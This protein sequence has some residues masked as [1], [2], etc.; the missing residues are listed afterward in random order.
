MLSFVPFQVHRRVLGEDRDALLALEVHRVHDALGDVLVGAEGAGLPEHG[1]DERRLAVVD[2]RDDRDV[3]EVGAVDVLRQANL[4]EVLKAFAEQNIFPL[5]IKGTPLS[6]IYYADSSLR[7]R[8]DTDLLIRKN[9]LN[10]VETILAKFG[11][12]RSNSVSGDFIRHQ[13]LYSKPG[14][15]GIGCDLDVHWKI[16]NPI[17][18]AD[19]LTFDELQSK[20]IGIPS[21]SEYARTVS[22]VD[23]LLLACLHR[24]AHHKSTERLIWLYDIHLMADRM[25]E[26]EF[27]EFWKRA[28]QKKLKS[29]CLDGLITAKS[30]FN[31]KF[32]EVQTDQ[33]GGQR[34][35]DSIEPSAQY[36]H[37]DLR[38]LD[39]LLMN[40]RHHSGWDK[41]QLLKENL[42][43]PASYMLQHYNVSKRLLLPGLYL[44]RSITGAWKWFQK[45]HQKG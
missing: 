31:T 4:Q 10:T 8:C 26:S 23:S 1:V 20:G 34:V 5:L 7:P 39:L 45:P 42:F 12:S 25:T 24:V 19:M 44:H 18:F 43:P 32:P 13:F 30:W 3:A 27:D 14:P 40:L 33:Q 28:S 16:S 11:Y 17:L 21:L 9:D 36:L 37:S 2:V 35:Y 6:Y 22:P 29:I 41:I 38:N 15:N